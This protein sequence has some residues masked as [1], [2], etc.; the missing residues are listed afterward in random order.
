MLVEKVQSRCQV[1][2]VGD[3]KVSMSS[4]ILLMW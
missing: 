1:V 2:T 4:R 3:E